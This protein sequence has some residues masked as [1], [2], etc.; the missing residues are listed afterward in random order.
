MIACVFLATTLSACA[1]SGSIA[2]P[3]DIRTLPPVPADIANCFRG[4][5]DI[6]QR[7]LTVSDVERLWSQ[8]RLR[9]VQQRQCG[10]RFLE[11]HNEIRAGWL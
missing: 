8:D 7:D 11:W 1:S 4:V 2:P 5:V 9:S 3:L 10:E 6:P